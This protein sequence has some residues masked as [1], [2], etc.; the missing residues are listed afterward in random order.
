MGAN[1]VAESNTSETAAD[2]AERCEAKHELIQILRSAEGVFNLF[3]LIILW[4]WN[5]RSKVFGF[6]MKIK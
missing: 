5:K 4:T 2:V 3:I 6:E 1:V